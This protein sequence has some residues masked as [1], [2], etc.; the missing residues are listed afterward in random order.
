MNEESYKIVTTDSSSDWRG[1][2]SYRPP[3]QRFREKIQST[4]G[5][6]YEPT[7][8]SP[9]HDRADNKAYQL[10]PQLTCSP[11]SLLDSKNMTMTDFAISGQTPSAMNAQTGGHPQDA[12]LFGSMICSSTTRCRMS[13][14]TGTCDCGNLHQR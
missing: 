3:M 10:Q 11:G 4:F 2:D 12:M 7:S 8:V 5:N 13:Q 9:R 14:V 6:S 1:H